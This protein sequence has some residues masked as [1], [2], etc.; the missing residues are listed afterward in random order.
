MTYPHMDSNQCG[1]TGDGF[2]LLRLFEDVDIKGDGV[3]DA[4]E[5]RWAFRAMGRDLSWRALDAWIH[6]QTNS[7]RYELTQEEFF[8]AVEQ[9][10]HSQ[11]EFPPFQEL[12][13]YPG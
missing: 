2:Y 6:E 8:K 1:T 4:D 3:I 12:C 11:V 7:K 5:L 13:S 10:M 9:T